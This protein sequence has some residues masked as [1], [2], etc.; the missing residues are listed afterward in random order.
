MNK[1]DAR[2]MLHE[3]VNESVLRLN[4]AKFGHKLSDIAP[5]HNK[6]FYLPEKTDYMPM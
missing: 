5:E 1:K 2:D 3:E 6:K 4:K